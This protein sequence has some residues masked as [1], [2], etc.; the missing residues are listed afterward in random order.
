MFKIPLEIEVAFTIKPVAFAIIPSPA[1]IL[2]V[3]PLALI[4][5]FERLRLSAD[6]VNVLVVLP[7]RTPFAFGIN[8]PL[9]SVLLNVRFP[10]TS[11]EPL[12]ARV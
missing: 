9:I 7:S 3:V 8:S 5:E 1:R 11:S 2:I 12:T 10:T 6:T 4:I